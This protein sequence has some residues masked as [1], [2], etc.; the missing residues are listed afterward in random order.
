[1]DKEINVN[2]IIKLLDEYFP[3]VMFASFSSS[4]AEKRK[5]E[6]QKLGAFAGK[7][8]IIA[9]GKYII[10]DKQGYRLDLAKMAGAKS[11]FSSL[12][13]GKKLEIAFTWEELDN[14]IRDGQHCV[15]DFFIAIED[16]NFKNA[17]RKLFD[18]SVLDQELD[19]Q[20]LADFFESTKNNLCAYEEGKF[21]WDFSNIIV[22]KKKDIYSAYYYYGR[23]NYTYLRLGME[24]TLAD[25]AEKRIEFL[26]GKFREKF[27]KRWE[28]VF[29]KK[30]WPDEPANIYAKM[31]E[32]KDTAPKKRGEDL[33]TSLLVKNARSKYTGDEKKDDKY[34]EL[35]SE[36]SEM[37][38]NVLESN[39]K[40]EKKGSG[41][42][43]PAELEDILNNIYGQLSYLE[44]N[45]RDNKD[46][47]SKKLN[48]QIRYAENKLVN[49][50]IKRKKK[51]ITVTDAEKTLFEKLEKAYLLEDPENK[52]KIKTPRHR[53]S[54]G[55][56]RQNA[57]ENYVARSND[58][59]IKETMKPYIGKMSGLGDWRLRGPHSV[60]GT[61]A[62]RDDA[63]RSVASGNIW[64]A[65]PDDDRSIPNYSKNEVSMLLEKYFDRDYEAEWFDYINTITE[66]FAVN[67]IYYNMKNMSA[68]YFGMLFKEYCKI[69]KINDQDKEIRDVFESRME[70]ICNELGELVRAGK[71][72]R[73]HNDGNN[74]KIY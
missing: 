70:S 35:F 7:M 40:V 15:T 51:G 71:K 21:V 33:I 72:P 49:L 34:S 52:K 73:R 31:T 8:G 38:I 36:Y 55:K 60:Y 27:E 41:K 61:F 69:S 13:P 24:L 5:V 2:E 67:V 4:L 17:F 62:K 37:I 50:I 56:D 47:F 6:K 10:S 63:D 58:E 20:I 68:Y 46:P 26:K 66:S 3:R 74:S 64:N 23:R 19:A 65:I 22:H 53:N 32:E 44:K 1:M 43:A 11:P 16:E 42:Y 45:I 28:R 12:F 39:L 14:T 25:L 30:T 29:G 48:D 59:E 57:I 18:A 54:T 9:D